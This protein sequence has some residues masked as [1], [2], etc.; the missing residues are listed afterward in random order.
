[1]CRHL[2]FAGAVPDSARIAFSIANARKATGDEESQAYAR[3]GEAPSPIT[4]TRQV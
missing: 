3:P 1:M 2:Y 4:F